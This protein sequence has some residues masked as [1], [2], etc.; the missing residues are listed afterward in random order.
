VTLYSTPG[1]AGQGGFRHV[2]HDNIEPWIMQPVI[3]IGCLAALASS[4]ELGLD[5]GWRF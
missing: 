4:Y 3:L 5:V 2:G 1:E